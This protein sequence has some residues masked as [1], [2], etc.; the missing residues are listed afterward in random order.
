M[1]GQTYYEIISNALGGDTWKLALDQ[2]RKYGIN[3]VRFRLSVKTCGVADNGFSCTM[4][5]EG[6][7]PDKL[8][9]N[10]F[11]ATDAVVGYM[12]KTG[13]VADLMPF[14]SMERAFGTAEQDLRFLR[15]VIARYAAYPNV[16]WCLTNE[17]QRTGRTLEYLNT[18]GD[19]LRAEDP[20]IQQGEGLRPLSIH[21]LG[22]KG[23][24]DLFKLGN[25]TWPVHVILQ[26]G[27]FRPGDPQQYSDMVANR[28]FGMPVV[29]DEFGYMGDTLG[30]WGRDAGYSRELH[31]NSMWAIYMAGGYASTGDKNKYPHGRPYKSSIWHEQPEYEDIA[32]LVKLFTTK[33][34]EYWKAQPDAADVLSGGRVYLLSQPGVQYLAYAASGGA[35]SLRLAEGRYSV[36]LYNPRNGSETDLPDVDG[37]ERTFETLAGTDWVIYMKRR[38]KP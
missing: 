35:F 13:M 38:H 27:R 4:P 3:K 20:W 17:F 23:E 14:N 37:G 22:R 15:Y 33:G 36:R 10:H 2:C 8:D 29:N 26:T 30:A 6:G 5:W 32:N 7:N 31:R 21:P 24:G 28:R 19:R 18:L 9:L 16:I 11:R 12:Y 25:R 1:V 34:V